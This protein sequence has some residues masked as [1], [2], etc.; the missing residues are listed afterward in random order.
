[1]RI[2]KTSLGTTEITRHANYLCIGF[3]GIL[4]KNSEL[5]FS[6]SVAYIILFFSI[7]YPYGTTFM[8]DA[9]LYNM[10]YWVLNLEHQTSRTYLLHLS[11]ALALDFSLENS[12]FR[13]L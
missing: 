1:M 12:A 3:L 8:H 10:V 2:Q 4:P 7:I 5:L 6:L 13:V 11:Y 9:Q